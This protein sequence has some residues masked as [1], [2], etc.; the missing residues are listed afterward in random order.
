V[1]IVLD[2]DYKNAYRV[3]EL[4]GELRSA[5]IKFEPKTLDF[6]IVPLAIENSVEFEIIA[7][8]Y[9]KYVNGGENGKT[10]TL[11]FVK[12][13]EIF[14]RSCEVHLQLPEVE[15]NDGD[16]MCLLS[17]TFPRGTTITPCHSD[18]PLRDT[19]RVP[20][21]LTF[22]SPKPVSFASEIIVNVGKER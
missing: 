8:G 7:N 19:C 18:D 22:R 1:P 5:D 13:F 2:D 10:N 15:M 3:V 16:R 12:L 21:K 11:F 14:F 9:R 20:C 17:S 4:E 6:K